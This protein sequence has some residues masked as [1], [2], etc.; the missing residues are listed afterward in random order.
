MM[1]PKNWMQDM[2]A[3]DARRAAAYRYV[4]SFLPGFTANAGLEFISSEEYDRRTLNPLLS[5]PF[6]AA[7]RRLEADG[8]L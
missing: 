5:L 1:A 8:C 2:R 7:I 4:E 3:R 6:Y